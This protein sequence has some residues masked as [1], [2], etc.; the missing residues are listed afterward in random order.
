MARAIHSL[1]KSEQSEEILNQIET[2][3]L[4]GKLQ[5]LHL[6]VKGLFRFPTPFSFVD[7]NPLLSLGLVSILFSSFSWHLQ[8]FGVSKA[9]Q[10]SPS[11]PHTMA[12]WDLHAGTPPDTGLSSVAFLSHGGRF[13][14]CSLL[15]LTLNPESCDQSCQVLLLAGAE[16][17][18]SHSIKSHW[19]SGFDGFLHCLKFTILELN[20]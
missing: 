9:T 4:L 8:N 17:W 7:C 10:S 14:N 13:H 1:S 2:E 15:F 11:L 3:N 6:P 19:L 18:P 20:L 12:F 16:T 5:T